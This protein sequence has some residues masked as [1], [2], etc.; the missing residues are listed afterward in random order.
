MLNA[1]CSMR[2]SVLRRVYAREAAPPSFNP[3]ESSGVADLPDGAL[4]CRGS[5]GN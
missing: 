1:Q 3:V 2:Y 4:S 5:Q